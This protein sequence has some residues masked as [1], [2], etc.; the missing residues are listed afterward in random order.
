MSDQSTPDRP[1]LETPI[2]HRRRAFWWAVII[3]FVVLLAWACSGGGSS[4][5]NGQVQYAC[6]EWVKERLKS[7]SSA[8]F[9]GV[10]TALSSGRWTSTGSVDAENSFGVPLRMSYTCVVTH[11]GSK[12]TLVSLDVR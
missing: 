1:W 2:S 6:K 9:S 4:S 8:N 3:G 5:A 11:D 7:P 10:S 12:S